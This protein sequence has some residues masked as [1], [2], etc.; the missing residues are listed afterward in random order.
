MHA[1]ANC[2]GLL[3]CRTHFE[4][5][6]GTRALSWSRFREWVSEAHAPSRV[7]PF[8][9][10]LLAHR[11]F[12]ILESDIAAMPIPQAPV[13]RTVPSQVQWICCVPAH[14]AVLRRLWRICVFRLHRRECQCQCAPRGRARS[15]TPTR[16]L[17]VT[18]KLA[19]SAHRT[20]NSISVT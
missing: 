9:R 15:L 8:E 11:W 14:F 16:P 19:L 12:P 13:S 7:L 4:A 20:R 18:A 5:L 17:P 6:N 2:C 3:K 1:C 10:G